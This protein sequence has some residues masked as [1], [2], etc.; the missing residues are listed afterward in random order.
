MTTTEYS[1]L[2]NG[3]TG[4]TGDGQTSNACP[5][6]YRTTRVCVQPNTKIKS[7]LSAKTSEIRYD[8]NR[9]RDILLT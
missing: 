8:G 3:N 1:L 6:P 4:Q 9:F 2:D 5:N 7:P